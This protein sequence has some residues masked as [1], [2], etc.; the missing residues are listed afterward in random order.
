MRRPTRSTLRATAAVLI[1]GALSTGCFG[2]TQAADT[3]GARSG[4]VVEDAGPPQ[5][6]GVLHIAATTDATS[7]DPQ[8]EASYTVHG[9][10]G[11]VYSRL[12]AFQTGPDVPYGTSEIEADLAEKWESPDNGKTWTF[13]L[14]HGVHF[15]DKAPVNGRELTSKDVLCTM[16]RIKKLPGH[17]VGL[18][19]NVA[20]IAAPD[21]YTVTFNLKQPYVAF[22]ETLANPFLVILPC[23]ATDGGFDP[24][25]D[26][27]GTGPFVLK[28]WK[29]D[30]ERVY[31]KNPDYFM[32]GLP[33][34]DGYTTTVIP[35]AQAQIAA[36]RSGKLDMITSLSTEKRQVD[37]LVKQLDGLQLRQEKG[38]TQTRVYMN[39]QQAPFDKLDV[40]RAV[41]MAIDRKSM[42]K[43]I[44]A[45]GQLTGP[46]T[47]TFF[48]AL[49]E[50]EV[51]ELNPY[52]PDRAKKLLADAGYP[53]GF[54]TSMVVTNGYGET[55]VREAQWVQQDLEKVGI[56]VKID[57]QDYAT[58]AGD[59][60]P[61]SKY[62][63]A[64]GLQTPML[65]ADEYFTTE[66]MSTGTRNW[67]LVDDPKLDQ[68]I[69]AQKTMADSG[70]REK[71]LQDLGRY[72]LENVATPLPLYVYDTQTLMVGKVHGY[73]P[74]PDYSARE[75]QDIWM[76][77]G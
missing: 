19:A 46:V 49:P 55:I 10:V 62:A 74:H 2:G 23:E 68:M 65:S 52:D 30:Q 16:D 43:S 51:A 61:K 50:D 47:P 63:I 25:K 35:D 75:Y 56:K 4:A 14:R 17:Q 31:V 6:G 60:W 24:A 18:I 76:E 69:T 53:N 73:F 67:S 20:D 22:D 13:H 1:C 48:G 36:L 44:R 37:A 39:A 21:D 8:K 45:G 40:R 26:A 64:Y 29:K 77:Q 33:H 70:Q 34:L 38:T 28:S 11:A 27:I 7:L 66:W 59:T 9:A 42:I 5:D 15:H 12:V 54:E 72:V 3:K 57:V 41:A 32:P 58:Y 71:A